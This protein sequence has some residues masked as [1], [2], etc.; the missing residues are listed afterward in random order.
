MSAANYVTKAGASDLY[1]QNSSKLV[2]ASTKDP[3]VRSFAQMMV[4]DHNKTTAEVKAGAAKAG[5]KLK[6]PALDAAKSKMIGELTAAKGAAR[7]RL[8]VQQQKIAHQEALAL[9]QGY[10]SSGDSAP[11]KAVA[12]TAV[13]IVEHHIEMLGA[14]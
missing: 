1:E 12:A 9:H 6:P 14:M 13:P 8:Y 3:K 4:K 11:L 2:L 7:D 5:L 10:S